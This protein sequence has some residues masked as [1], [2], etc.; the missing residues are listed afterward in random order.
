MPGNYLTSFHILSDS[1]FVLQF[2]TRSQHE[3]GCNLLH[4]GFLHGL[5]ADPEVGVTYSST[6]S[7]EFRGINSQKTEHF[8]TTSVRTSDPTH[9]QDFSEVPNAGYIDPE[10]ATKRKE[11]DAY[12]RT[13]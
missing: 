5:H 11:G 9:Y 6:P 1:S 4:A 13:T 2:D 12:T 8:I 7:I 3:A 10:T